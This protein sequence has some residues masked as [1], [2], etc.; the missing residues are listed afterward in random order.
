MI[1]GTLSFKNNE[2][3]FARNGLLV[4]EIIGQAWDMEQGKPHREGSKETSYLN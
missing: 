3:V 1:V 4:K 2:E